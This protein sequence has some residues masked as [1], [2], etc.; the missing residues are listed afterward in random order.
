MLRGRRSPRRRRGTSRQDT[1]PNRPSAAAAAR[2]VGGAYGASTLF[3]TNMGQGS[4]PA[5]SRNDDRRPCGARPQSRGTGASS[6]ASMWLS[7]C[8]S[9]TGTRVG[10][11]HSASSPRRGDRQRPTAERDPVLALHLHPNGRDRPHRAGRIDLVPRRQPDIP[12]PRRRE[13]QKLERQ[14][15]GG[16][17]RA[18][19]SPSRWPRLRPCRAAP[20][21]ASRCRSAEPRPAPPIARVV[22][23]QVHADRPLQHRADALADLPGRRRL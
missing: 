14:L 13:H 9:S 19:A 21:G 8:R 7:A 4:S 6:A 10:C 5:P 2:K 1:P 12:G 15:D 3:W 20:P 18:R 16:L 23:A 22:V 17:R 11:R